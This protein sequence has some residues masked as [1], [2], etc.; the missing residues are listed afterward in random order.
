[1]PLHS[2]KNRLLHKQIPSNCGC[3]WFELLCMPRY[4]TTYL[5]T[6]VNPCFATCHHNRQVFGLLRFCPTNL[7]Y[8]T[9]T[10]KPAH[11]VVCFCAKC[12]MLAFFQGDSRHFKNAFNFICLHRYMP[13]EQCTIPGLCRINWGMKP[14]C[15]AK[16]RKVCQLKFIYDSLEI[17]ASRAWWCGP[18]RIAFQRTW[19]RDRR[20]LIPSGPLISG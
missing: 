20:R 16:K 14:A 19:L 4:G 3:T 18:L 13:S 6:W 17:A 7:P 1:M 11:F 9:S 8:R 10:R 5:Q 12:I 2:K 15:K